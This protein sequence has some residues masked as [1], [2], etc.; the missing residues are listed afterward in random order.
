M[1]WHLQSHVPSRFSP[2]STMLHFPCKQNGFSTHCFQSPADGVCSHHLVPCEKQG[3]NCR[4]QQTGAW[5][6]CWHACIGARG[7]GGGPFQL[8]GPFPSDCPTGLHVTFWLTAQTTPNANTLR[9]LW[10]ITFQLLS[11]QYLNRE[12][13][14]RALSEGHEVAIILSY[15]CTFT[16]P[17]TLAIITFCLIC[18]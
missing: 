6:N 10:A 3:E 14:K 18:L 17:P 13:P 15:C 1:Y 5:G 16:P 12:Y 11:Y 9:D 8:E 4:Q 2:L 7:L